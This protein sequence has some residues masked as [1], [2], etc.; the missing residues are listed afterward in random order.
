M[1]PY[2]LSKTISIFYLYL[3]DDYALDFPYPIYCPFTPSFS[4]LTCPAYMPFVADGNCRL[5][6]IKATDHKKYWIYSMFAFKIQKIY[7]QYKY[8][9]FLKQLSNYNIKIDYITLLRYKHRFRKRW[10]VEGYKK[11]SKINN[12]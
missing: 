8:N 6:S 7:F 10:N 2:I 12:H 11:Y 1:N 9:N 5:C 4:K 3:P